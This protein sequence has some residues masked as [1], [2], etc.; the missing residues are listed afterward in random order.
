MRC[1]LAFG[2]KLTFPSLY[3]SFAYFHAS[4]QP[5]VL[6]QSCFSFLE[7]GTQRFYRDIG[8]GEIFLSH[9]PLDR[10][11]PGLSTGHET[12][13]MSMQEMLP[14]CLVFIQTA[15]FFETI[16]HEFVDCQFEKCAIITMPFVRALYISLS[17][18]VGYPCEVLPVKGR[19]R[20]FN[21]FSF[22]YRFERSIW[23]ICSNS[24][25]LTFDFD[26]NAIVLIDT[27]EIQNYP[28]PFV[29]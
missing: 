1:M 18:W 25:C 10:F 23:Y 17:I 5:S 11:S 22:L 19:K 9:K 2:L 16:V 8:P 3:S 13:L 24:F 29:F 14:R 26:F 20:I 7:A 6:A 15:T 27:A 4:S 28:C 21:Q 12:S